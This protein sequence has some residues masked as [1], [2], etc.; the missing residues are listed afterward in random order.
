MYAFDRWCFKFYLNSGLNVELQQYSV[1]STYLTSQNAFKQLL[2]LPDLKIDLN[3]ILW[4]SNY[5][6]VLI[7]AWIS[8]FH[9][10]YWWYSWIRL[11]KWKSSSLSSVLESIQ[12]TCTYN[13]L[14][15]VVVTW[16]IRTSLISMLKW[17]INTE[18]CFSRY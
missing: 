9:D 18:F 3:S 17:W 13:I 10:S 2:T 5:N 8:R 14:L 16:L 11:H 7:K 12:I 15:R 6:I 4:M 1:C